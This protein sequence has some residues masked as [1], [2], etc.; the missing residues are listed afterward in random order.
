MTDTINS[1]DELNNL[2][3]GGRSSGFNSN[4]YF[5]VRYVNNE[6]IFIV[7]LTDLLRSLK[8]NR[9]FDKP[10]KQF[11]TCNK[12][13]VGKNGDCTDCGS[14]LKELKRTSPG[15][16]FL[17]ANLNTMFNPIGKKDDGTEYVKNFLQIYTAKQGDG[18]ENFMAIE[19]NN[20]EDPKYYYDDPKNPDK[21]NPELLKE[22][23]L[24]FTESG[25]DKVWKIKR[26]GG[27]DPV[28]GLQDKVSYP[29]ISMVEHKDVRKALGLEKDTLIRVPKEIRDAVNKLTLKDLAGH[30]LTQ[31]N[32]INWEPFAKLGVFPPGEGSRIGDAPKEEVKDREAAGAKL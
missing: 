32:D 2:E 3:S 16:Y 30:Y 21:V 17:V 22:N 24:F 13:Y 10:A 7:F 12:T 5:G 15:R 31:V 1:L 23:G 14:S 11:R 29:P 28:T 9:H 26:N 20:G 25:Q 27:K 19:D 4:A 6:E 18:G 8:I